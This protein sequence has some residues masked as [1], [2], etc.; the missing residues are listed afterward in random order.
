[1]DSEAPCNELVTTSGVPI[2]VSEQRNKIAVVHCEYIG[3]ASL[4]GYVVLAT[5]KKTK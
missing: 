5:I 4:R 1:M 2:D 3:F